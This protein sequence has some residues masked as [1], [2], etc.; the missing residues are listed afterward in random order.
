M[1][2]NDPRTSQGR[3][4]RGESELTS[5][6]ASLLDLKNIYALC[7]FALY[8]L[9]QGGGR[10]KIELP[11]FLVS[12]IFQ[13]LKNLKKLPSVCCGTPILASYSPTLAGRVLKK[14]CLK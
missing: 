13:Y 4:M 2:D 9:F 12:F 6:Q 1:I 11:T 14:K 10:D 8:F 7:G 5:F 3:W